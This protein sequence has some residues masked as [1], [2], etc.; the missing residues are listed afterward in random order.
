[1]ENNEHIDVKD[2]RLMFDNFKKQNINF[3]EILF[4]KFGIVNEKYLDE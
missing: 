4:T 2:I 3:L 1:M